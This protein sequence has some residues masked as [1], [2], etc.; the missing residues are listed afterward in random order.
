[1][2][3][4]TPTPDDTEVIPAWDTSTPLLGGDGTAPLNRQAQS[5]LNKLMGYVA[6]YAASR[7][8]SAIGFIQSGLSALGM[9]A[10]DK[11]R[12]VVNAKDFGAS[13]T[14]TTSQNR[15]AVQAGIAELERRGGG[16]LIIDADCPY[17]YKVTDVTTHP[18]FVGIFSDILVR[19]RSAGSSYASPAKDGAQE[20]LFFYTYQQRLPLT[21][22]ATL[23]SGATS[24][25]LASN[26]PS[27][28]GPYAVEFSNG[29]QRV[30]MLTGGSTTA[31]WLTGGGGLSSG[32]TASAHYVNPGNND[33]DTI[34][35][36]STW[37]PFLIISND[38][39][40]APVGDPSRTIN[41]NRRAHMGFAI[42]GVI[43]FYHGIGTLSG[44]QYSDGQMGNYHL[45]RNMASAT[46]W[47]TG[48]AYVKNQN[49]KQGGLQYVCLADH[50]S[51]T[52]S[53]DL[54]TGNWFLT[55]QETSLEIV[56]YETG[57]V[58]FNSDSNGFVAGYHFK[59]RT[60]GVI[61][62]LKE[63]LGPNCYDVL[64]N[65]AG[66]SQDVL[67]Q[68]GSGNLKIS[69]NAGIAAW[70]DY[71]GRTGFGVSTTP[72]Y[73][74]EVIESR[75]AQY[76]AS[77]RNNDSTA[78]YGISVVSGTTGT[79]AFS[80]ADFYDLAGLKCAIRGNGNIV[81]TNNSYGAISD[82][83]F[84]TNVQPAPSYWDKVKK[85]GA[86]LKTYSLIDDPTGE[87][88]L[89]WVAQD[90]LGVSNGLV[91]ETP[92]Y[93]AVEETHTRIDVRVD[94]KTGEKTGHPV[95]FTEVVRKPLGTTS[96]A[97]KYSIASL[98]SVGVTAEAA[99]RIEQLEE[100][101]ERQDATI[102]LLVESIE[103]LKAASNT[104]GN[105]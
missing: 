43:T 62:V 74:L 31:T 78:G 11:L 102:A 45:M 27:A 30:V 92:D 35:Q 13:S 56:E 84:K 6:K 65:S 21:F 100:R 95:T 42:D 36:R 58:S 86:L 66:S 22:N 46:N 47:V 49:V 81:N 28:T 41:D 26:W 80:L 2:S 61:Q 87:K 69:T 98:M 25:T 94:E 51:G 101:V 20:R 97:V 37:A 53:T 68:N 76:A 96:L 63:S 70:V 38:S 48:K 88:L 89:G 82:V 5:L 24:G 1:M 44:Y 18:S 75:N 104:E 103:K 52:F 40:L 14:N 57:R 90:L 33:G 83:K 3:N 91:E 17:G 4:L 93:E 72:N 79:T 54:G 32:A 10:E 105:A 19:D 39:A 60:P 7:G 77:F 73:K 15:T 99:E 55:P 12:Q 67:L 85:L 23:A 8:A 50:T 71:N 59:E 9:T 29:D 64:R 34:W 16:T